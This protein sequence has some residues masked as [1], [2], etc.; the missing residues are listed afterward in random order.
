MPL[1]VD[2]PRLLE[3][4]W[5]NVTLRHLSCNTLQE[6]EL[7]LEQSIQALSDRFTKERS[8]PAKDYFA[9]PVSL[10]AYGL[11]FFPQ[12]YVRTSFVLQEILSRGWKPPDPMS[13][14]DLGAG[15]GA[16]SLSVASLFSS[17]PATITAV[18]HSP[19]ALTSMLELA[20]G[21]SILWPSLQCKTQ[22][23]DF[24]Q[25]SQ[26]QKAKWDLILATFALNESNFSSSSA[27]DILTNLLTE[28]GLL[29]IIEPAT[30]TSSEKLES[31]RD[32]ITE[33]PE[34]HIWG[35]CLHRSSCPLLREGTYWCHDVRSWQPPAGLRF[36]NRHLYRQI[37]LLKFS[38]LVLGKKAPDPVAPLSFRLISP[39]SKRKKSLLFTGCTTEGIKKDFQV[40]H[41]LTEHERKQIKSWGRGDIVTSFRLNRERFS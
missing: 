41:T 9:D 19:A 39:V 7:Q 21:C 33:R 28:Q 16:A 4:W 11:F 23:A 36:F 1:H 6:R 2:Y 29:V 38:F 17:T 12:S 34:L 40:F 8:N 25:W 24:W 31:W 5:I 14:L 10:C 3:E 35:P 22:T 18:D 26:R 30:K 32:T 37:H 20:S 27:T 15:T 13:I